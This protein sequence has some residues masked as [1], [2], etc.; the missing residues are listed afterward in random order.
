MYVRSYSGQIND[1]KRKHTT[2]M[3]YCPLD[4]LDHQKIKLLYVLYAQR[5]DNSF[6][7]FL[8]VQFLIIGRLHNTVYYGFY[9]NNL[10]LVLN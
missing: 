1:L 8:L 4:I 3:I 7:M 9:P 2:E 6:C 10:P 5:F